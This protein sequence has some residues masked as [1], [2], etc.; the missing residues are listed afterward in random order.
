MPPK[1]RPKA[2]LHVLIYEDTK[3]ILQNLADDNN[4]TLASVTQIVIEKGLGLNPIHSLY[5]K[6]EE[7]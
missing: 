3:E 6:V 7:S 4:R 1:I 5:M 2:V